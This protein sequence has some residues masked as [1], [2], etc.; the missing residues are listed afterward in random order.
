M[1]A[2]LAWPGIAPTPPA[3]QSTRYRLRQAVALTSTV[4]ASLTTAIKGST[5]PEIRGGR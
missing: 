5:R 3:R 2:D 4:T 1:R